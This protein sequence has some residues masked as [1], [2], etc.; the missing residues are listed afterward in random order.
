MDLTL[1]MKDTII[2]WGS[3][4]VLARNGWRYALE[5]KVSL[6][7][8]MR[9]SLRKLT[10]EARSCLLWKWERRWV[11]LCNTCLRYYRA[12][13]SFIIYHCIKAMN[14]LPVKIFHNSCEKYRC[15]NVQRKRITVCINLHKL[16]KFRQFH[17]INI[18][19]YIKPIKTHYR[20]LR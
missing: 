8:S 16:V 6:G 4:V 19:W 12:S 10:W 20:Y 7:W 18:E 3:W 9:W 11:I 14:D 1:D 17:V 2:L 13:G 15:I 5:N